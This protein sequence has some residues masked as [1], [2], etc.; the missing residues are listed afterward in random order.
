MHFKYD[1]DVNYNEERK[2]NNYL[3]VKVIEKI[4]I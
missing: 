3:Y 2:G 1:K 4:G